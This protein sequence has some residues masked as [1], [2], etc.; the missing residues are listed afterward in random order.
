VALGFAVSPVAGQNF[1]ARLGDRVRATFK[2]GA[3]MAVGYQIFFII[4]CQIA[5]VAM[6]RVFS[7]DP[8]VLAA[9]EEYLRVIS[10]SFVASGLI[11][12]ASSMCQAMGNTVPSLI[13]SGT[14][15]VVLAVPVM[16]LARLSS[17]RLDWVWYLSLTTSYFQL[18]LALLLLR[19]EFVRRLDFGVPAPSISIQAPVAETV[20]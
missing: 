5:P 3:A 1:G 9:G 4:I 20:S 17:F 2:D 14:R 19:R 6:V 11:F 16:L 10:W 7:K 13:A 12:V 15:M 8:A 18:G